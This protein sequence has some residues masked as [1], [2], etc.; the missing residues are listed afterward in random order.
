MVV[1]RARPGRVAT[2]RPLGA[3]L[4]WATARA[5][6]R[7]PAT[8]SSSAAAKRKDE[9]NKRGNVA[10]CAMP[11]RVGPSP[12]YCFGHRGGGLDEPGHL[13]PL[14]LR[15]EIR[16]PAPRFQAGKG[17]GHLRSVTLIEEGT[18]HQRIPQRQDQ[19]DE[20]DPGQEGDP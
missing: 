3:S 10:C 11:N 5:S 6:P 12:S 7:R 9:R 17:R 8:S 15:P 2:R 4:R 20:P 14:P 1:A 19:E 16:T 13:A 18:V